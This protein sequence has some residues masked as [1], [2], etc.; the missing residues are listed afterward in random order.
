ML[1]LV[2]FTTSN[3]LKRIY[4]YIDIIFFLSLFK[5]IVLQLCDG[6]TKNDFLIRSLFLPA[7]TTDG[8]EL[9][10]F[11]LCIRNEK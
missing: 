1:F 8:L 10:N 6:F 11:T 7:R 9:C 5:S 2:A 3:K 4:I